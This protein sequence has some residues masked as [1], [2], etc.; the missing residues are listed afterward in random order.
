MSKPVSFFTPIQ[1]DWESSTVRQK[2]TEMIDACF[3]LKGKVAIVA[4]FQIKGCPVARLEEKQVPLWSLGLKVASLIGP[5]LVSLILRV[6]F[7]ALSA[8][9]SVVQLQTAL[10]L[11]PVVMLILKIALRSTSHLHLYAD[12]DRLKRTLTDLLG[13]KGPFDELPRYT[14]DLD[15]V[16]INAE[17]TKSQMTA[18]IM[19]GTEDVDYALIHLVC[20]DPEMEINRKIWNTT[21]EDKTSKNHPIQ[22]NGLVLLRQAGPGSLVWRQQRMEGLY[23]R[24]FITTPDNFT[25]DTG[26]L[27]PDHQKGFEL[28]QKIIR[29]EHGEDLYRIRWKIAPEPHKS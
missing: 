10:S 25:Y 16:D 21:A 27:V 26:E 3:H 5:L 13:A 14:E 11:I 7:P 23:P 6:Q 17:P 1:Y 28:L 15:R 24:F 2:M 18:S 12:P 29:G 22:V 19:K 20:L 9:R 8:Y 4:P